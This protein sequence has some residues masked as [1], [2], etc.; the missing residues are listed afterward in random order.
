MKKYLLFVLCIVV[1][2]LSKKIYATTSFTTDR[3]SLKIYEKYDIS[4]IINSDSNNL[5]YTSS[6]ENIATISK[7]GIIFTKKMGEFTITVSDGSSTDTCKF[8]SGYYVGIDV[9]K[10]NGKVDWARVKEQGIDF[11]MIRS[12]LGWYDEIEDKDHE[13]EFQYDEQLLN[14][15]KGASENNVSFGIYHYSYADT[16]EKAILEAE[17]VLNAI[18]EYGKEYK[19]KMTLPI[20]YDIEEEKAAKVGKAKLTEIAI[21]FCTK[22]YEA[23]YTPIIYSN[24][25]FFL[26]Y[27][28][29]DKL[30]AMAYNYW[31]ASPKANPNF[32]DKIT[33]GDTKTSPFIWQYSFNGSVEGANTSDGTV[34]MNVLYMKDRVK[35][36]VKDNGQVVD[37]IGAD[38]GGKID[39]IP[40]YEKEGY[41]LVGFKD[42]NNNIIDSDKEYNEDTIITPT[43]EK[44]K[45]TEI[46][47]NKRTL[48]ISNK[49]DYYLK[50]NRVLPDNA[51]LEGEKLIFET[52]NSKIA[53]VDQNGTVTPLSDGTCKITCKLESNP[54]VVATCNVNVHFGIVKG[55]LDRNGV[56]TANDASIVLDIY[57][58]GTPTPEQIKIGDMDGNGTLTAN[59]ASMI[60]DMYKNGQ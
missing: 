5:K 36:E 53:K 11:A 7:E 25:N 1:L 13:Y 39:Y 26:N 19:E 29:L 2:T 28:N 42:K 43:F 33:I 23:G 10:W 46:V 27:L 37:T 34:D 8:S 6:N 48:E 31:Y 58:S 4:Q 17:Y 40:K 22:I 30:N 9:S 47:L 54:K 21:T 35:V 55:D 44:I 12:S 3:K 59:D 15:L 52:D 18:N 16:I 38:K 45:I 32:S 14:N 20:A 51:I 50:V 24:K 49:E 57:K 60:L 41:N 56:I